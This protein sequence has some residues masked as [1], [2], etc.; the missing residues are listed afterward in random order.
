MLTTIDP[1][2]MMR[3]R[4]M[5]Y[6]VRALFPEVLLGMYTDLEMNDTQRED[7]PVTIT[8]DGGIVIESQE[9][10]DAVIFNQEE[11]N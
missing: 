8:E 3:A 6:A 2:E 9:A 11:S 4:C 10:T 7:S 5:A 1:K